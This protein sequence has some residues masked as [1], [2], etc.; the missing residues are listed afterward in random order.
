ML[1]ISYKEFSE[2]Q[3][4]RAATEVFK[5]TCLE[6]DVAMTLGKLKIKEAKYCCRT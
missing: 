3:I 1:D 2:N 4:V 6:T 5:T